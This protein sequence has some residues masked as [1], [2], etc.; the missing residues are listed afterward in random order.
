MHGE[1]GTPYTPP[2]ISSIPGSLQEVRSIV[3]GGGGGFSF[4]GNFSP[5]IL[6]TMY[7]LYLPS[8]QSSPGLGTKCTGWSHF[9]EPQP[10]SAEVP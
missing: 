9:I 1:N 3:L 4:C 7:D 8:Q 6:V 10:R 2:E 5:K